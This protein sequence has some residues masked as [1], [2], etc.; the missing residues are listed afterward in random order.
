M[1]T[2]TNSAAAR[3]SDWRLLALSGLGDRKPSALL[4]HMDALTSAE[5]RKTTI[6]RALFLSHLPQSVRLILARDPPADIVDL[7]TAADDILA[8]QATTTQL[9]S[10]AQ[11]TAEQVSGSAAEKTSK[12]FSKHCYY[13]RKF[14]NKAIKCSHTDD[15]PCDMKHLLKSV[16]SLTPAQ[17]IDQASIDGKN[18][19]T[20]SDRKTGST[21]LVDSGAD[22]SC[23]PASAADRRTLPPSTLL[24]AA[25][26]SRISTWG[27]RN[28]AI[29]L[30]TSSYTW[31]FHV[32]NVEHSL[33]GADFLVTP[34]Y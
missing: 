1:L 31:S 11:L 13:H 33:L 21:Y 9:N 27:K 30:G 17:E 16:K 25:N 28:V 5:D 4:R 24:L 22:V 2:M 26:G 8:T 6:F 19:L 23:I 34:S 29:N 32:A 20:I 7:A 14:G 18:T 15:A 3:S 12:H 10:T